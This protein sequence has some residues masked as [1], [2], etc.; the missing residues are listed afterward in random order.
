MHAS[1]ASHNKVTPFDKGV[2]G[3][4][5]AVQIAYPTSFIM[6]KQLQDIEW[7]IN[8]RNPRLT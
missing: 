4:L 5:C 6:L 8:I 1:R 7:T 3:K 2:I